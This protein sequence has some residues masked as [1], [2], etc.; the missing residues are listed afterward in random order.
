MRQP[1]GANGERSSRTRAV[2]RRSAKN[3]ASGIVPHRRMTSASNG[4]QR[5]RSASSSVT[6]M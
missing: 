1:A 4:R 6:T 5:Q 3:D 2:T